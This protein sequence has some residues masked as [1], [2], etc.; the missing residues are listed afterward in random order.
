V[1]NIPTGTTANKVVV[2]DGSAKLP[3]VDGSALTNLNF[4]T[5]I[6]GLSVNTVYQAASAGFV[7]IS[8]TTNTNSIS[9]VTDSSNPPTTTKGALSGVVVNLT[10]MVPI[11]SGNYYKATGGAT[12]NVYEFWPL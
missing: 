3:A 1:A 7:F 4:G 10:M 6:T 12:I 11:I 9:I 2:L 8:V 5:P